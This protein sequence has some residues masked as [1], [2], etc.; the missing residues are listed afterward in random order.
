MAC[1]CGL[2][3][4]DMSDDHDVDVRLLL[5]HLARLRQN[6]PRV[7]TSLSHSPNPRRCNKTTL[8]NIWINRIQTRSRCKPR[9]LYTTFLP[10]KTIEFS[11]AYGTE[12]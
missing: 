6:K 1:G 5:S 10:S 12:A 8:T 7:S 4:V 9:N 3:R 11:N 2:T